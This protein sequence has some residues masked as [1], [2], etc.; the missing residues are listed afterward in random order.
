MKIDRIDDSSS[1]LKICQ[2]YPVNMFTKTPNDNN[3]IHLDYFVL[4]YV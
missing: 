4:Q 1:R 3:N 2:K